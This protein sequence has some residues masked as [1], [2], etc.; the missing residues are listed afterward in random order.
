MWF[1]FPEGFEPPFKTYSG[2]HCLNSS[3]ARH[4]ELTIYLQAS[5]PEVIPL[6]TVYS[7]CAKFRRKMLRL[8]KTF[9]RSITLLSERSICGIWTYN[10]HLMSEPASQHSLDNLI[11]LETFQVFIRLKSAYIQPYRTCAI[12]AATVLSG[13][14]SLDTTRSCNYLVI[15]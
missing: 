7:A 2:L 9:Y 3:V 11:S 5:E 13:G 1:V 4:T 15:I 14:D 10:T 12:F 8:L 6:T